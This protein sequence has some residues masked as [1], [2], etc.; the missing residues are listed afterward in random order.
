LKAHLGRI[1]EDTPEHQGVVV[2]NMADVPLV[3][4]FFERCEKSLEPRLILEWSEVGRGKDI[5]EIGQVTG[6]EIERT[7]DARRRVMAQEKREV[8][9]KLITRVSALQHVQLLILE[10]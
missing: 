9:K 3:S 7:K 5:N 6:T 10:N 4:L 8:R 1:T 2:F